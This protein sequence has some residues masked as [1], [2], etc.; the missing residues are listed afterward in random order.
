MS[1]SRLHT[2]LGLGAITGPLLAFAGARLTG[3]LPGPAS[4]RAAGAGTKET[5]FTPLTRTPLTPR[6]LQSLES[7]PDRDFAAV[8]YP[9][10]LAPASSEVAE[11]AEAPGEEPVPEFAV[12]SFMGGRSPLVI[13]DSRPRRV[14]DDLGNGW[15][16]TSIDPATRSFTVA[17]GSRTET[18][19]AD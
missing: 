10:Y 4:A 11:P 9:F 16:L 19:Q 14:G 6:Q 8:P 13:I 1:T 12:S 2:L 18:V 5:A 3:H 15:T 7:M 17:K